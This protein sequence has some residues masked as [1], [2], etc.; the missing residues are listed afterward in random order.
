MATVVV[1]GGTGYTGGNVVREASA[2]GH[3]VVSVSR[4]EPK[5][6]VEGVRYE[7]GTVEQVAARVVP[8]ADVV[9]AALSPR[10][11]MSGRLVETYRDLAR[12]SAAAGP[13]YFQVGGYSSLR[14]AAGEPRFVEGDLP[15]QFRDEALEGEATRVMLVEEAPEALDWVFVSPA[16]A[17]GAWAAGERTGRYRVGED[18]A[19][20]DD[21]GGSNIS[22]G[23][24]A[25]AIVDEVER[26][27]R[28]RA[29]MSV[30]Y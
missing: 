12:Q 15:E 27:T 17:Y 20:V 1:F 9:V 28:H 23:D 29:H 14:P 30:A 6:P 25:A 19:L 13:R 16:G 4:S 22:G 11:D 10:G 18:V 5:D 26:P 8:E 7:T 24:F 21:E 3:Q 2:R